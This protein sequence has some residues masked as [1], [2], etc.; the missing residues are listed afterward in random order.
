MEQ[1]KAID[2]EKYQETRTRVVTKVHNKTEV[3]YD[4][5]NKLNTVTILSSSYIIVLRSFLLDTLCSYNTPP[6][7]K[8]GTIVET[9]LNLMKHKSRCSYLL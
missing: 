5:G 3:T 6:H 9:K 4:K 2:V 8:G 7:A 1:R